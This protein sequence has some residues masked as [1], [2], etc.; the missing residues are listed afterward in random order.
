[1]NEANFT[2]YMSFVSRICY[3][4]ELEDY[5]RARDLSDTLMGLMVDE[6]IAKMDEELGDIELED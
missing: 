5:E 2:Y 6:A 1:M 3:A 4:M